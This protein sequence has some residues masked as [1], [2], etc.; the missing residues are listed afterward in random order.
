PTPTSRAWWNTWA[1]SPNRATHSTRAN[2][3]SGCAAFPYRSP[4][5]PPPQRCPSPARRAGSPRTLSTGSRPLCSASP[6]HSRRNRQHSPRTW[7]DV[8]G[9]CRSGAHHATAR[10]SAHRPH[11]QGLLRTTDSAVPVVQR[12]AGEAGPVTTED[13]RGVEPGPVTRRLAV[14]MDGQVEVGEHPL[15]RFLPRGQTIG[16]V[17]QGNVRGESAGVLTRH[18]GDRSRRPSRGTAW[19]WRAEGAHVQ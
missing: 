17:D 2:R 16:Q 4:T 1:K 14:Q 8:V 15:G 6:S 3:N 9:A 5:H 19:L 12:S 18:E 10:W 11:G 13:D 7:T